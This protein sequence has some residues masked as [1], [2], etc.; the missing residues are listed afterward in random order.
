MSI[1]A[2]SVAANLVLIIKATHSATSDSDWANS[3]KLFGMWQ[4]VKNPDDKLV[5]TVD[6]RLVALK[7]KSCG[8][9]T[10]GWTLD[11]ANQLTIDGYAT[12]DSGYYSMESRIK[13]DEEKGM[14]TFDQEIL[15]S[16]LVFH[17]IGS[18]K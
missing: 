15:D 10:Q 13:I 8:W 11:K 4:S 14:L 1:L 18:I 3:G 17:Q 12:V 2:I 16:G 5:F 7:G 9:E 6:H